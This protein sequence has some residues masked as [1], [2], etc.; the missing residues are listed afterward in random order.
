MVFNTKI[1]NFINELYDSG[2]NWREIFTETPF[3]EGDKNIRKGG[4]T[5]EFTEEEISEYVKCSQDIIYFAEKYCKIKIN[6]ELS[7]LPSGLGNLVLLNFQKE[8]LKSLV[9]EKHIITLK[10]R[11]TGITSMN[12]VYILH[13]CMFSSDKNVLIAA[14]MRATTIEIVDKIKTFYENLPFWLK[15][16]VK[17][18]NQ[19]SIIFDNGC[20]IKTIART[21]SAAIG[22]EV[23]QLFIEEAAHIPSNIMDSFYKSFHDM[24]TS[25]GKRIVLSSSPNG[26]NLFYHLYTDAVN[27]NNTYFPIRI[28]YTLVP[29]RDEKWKEQTIKEIGGIE[30]FE[31]EYELKFIDKEDRLKSIEDKID[32]L[33][34]NTIEIINDNGDIATFKI[35]S[36]IELL[37]RLERIERN[38]DMIF[39]KLKL[40]EDDFLKAQKVVENPG[41]V[42]WED[43][44]A[45]K[46]RVEDL[47]WAQ[48]KYG[49]EFDKF[50][51]DTYNSSNLTSF[52]SSTPLS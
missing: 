50:K 28:D 42:M 19:V 43:V 8:Y 22:Y 34:D 1:I 17:S 37:E 38:I 25:T 27:K 36:N 31:Q 4:L 44:E 2:A 41:Q 51:F 15:P 49:D 7:I 12:A 18:W 35:P 16:G 24:L 39:S 11:Q 20:K 32:Q 29:S 3:Y 33:S 9:K 26:K 45:Y 13:Y 10:A 21:K 30:A 40:G 23:H 6:T 52:T 5:Y 14:N 48:N 47:K 46:K